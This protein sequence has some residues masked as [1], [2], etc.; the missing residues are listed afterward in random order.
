MAL[1]F[2]EVTHWSLADWV[3]VR[4]LFGP[5]QSVSLAKLLDEM[6]EEATLPD[7][8]VYDETLDSDLTTEGEPGVRAG[9]RADAAEGAS[10]EALL[11]EETI[12]EIERRAGVVGPSY[13]IKV[14]TSV[15]RLTVGAW[16]DAPVY[17]FLVALNAR[18]LWD[19]PADLH[20]GAR[21]FE[22]LVVPAL[23][24]YWGGEAAHFGWPRDAAEH[25]P[26]QAAL[27]RLLSQMRERLNV[28]PH[29]LPLAQKDLA[30]DAV[31]WRPL[32]DRPGQT[33]LLCQ[34]SVGKDW[35]EKGVPIE[36]W[37][38]LVNFAVTPTRGLAFPFLPEAV[39]ALS[40]VDWL[41]LC[42]GVGVPFDRLRLA[43]LISS[44]EVDEVLVDQLRA[45][46]DTLSASLANL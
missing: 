6:V 2:S 22:R 4:L 1:P 15:A 9:L 25:G 20:A 29:Q 46:T 32:D 35:S 42:A 16:R 24:R 38:T 7:L 21:L 11:A 34:C 8:A 23:R 45:W 14:R 27:P 3:E 13:P 37:T 19:L 10:P 40:E 31:A 17:A 12:A 33:V 28:A 43:Y 36:K 26:F 18:Y 5:E 44:S 39:R 30:V 41:L